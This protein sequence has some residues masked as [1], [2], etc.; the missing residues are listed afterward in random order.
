MQDCIHSPKNIS[1]DKYRLDWFLLIWDFK[2]EKAEAVCHSGDLPTSAFY[3]AQNAA[4]AAGL[5][6]CHQPLSANTDCALLTLQSW[7]L[8]HW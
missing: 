7:T 5:P 6:A 3:W 2:H 1:A 8:L 4:E